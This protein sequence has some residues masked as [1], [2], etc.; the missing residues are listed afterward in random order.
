MNRPFRKGLKSSAL[1]SVTLACLFLNVGC[2]EA[3]TVIAKVLGKSPNSAPVE[4][5][6]PVTAAISGPVS[7]ALTGTPV[8]GRLAQ[9]TPA[10][11][12]RTQAP[13][14]TL[15]P[16]VQAPPPPP[17]GAPAGP[18]AVSQ[19][20]QIAAA[21]PQA[22]PTPAA[23][24]LTALNGKMRNPGIGPPMGGDES[25]RIE[26]F[27]FPGRDPFREPTEMLPPRC[28]PSQP[29]CKFD[30]SQLRLVGVMQVS[31]GNFKGMV[32]DPEGR[33]Y[34]VTT[35]MMIGRATVTQIG[36][37]G[38]ILHVHKTNN[39]VLMPMSREGRDILD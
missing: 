4:S 25:R 31:D 24:I 2:Q 7:L 11:L 15:G 22:A 37:K 12:P 30:H 17:Q 3:D 36:N 18:P 9:N 21:A 38:V 29:L 20:G 35:G 8:L 26:P 14:Q 19:P 1:L 28:L 16:I 23:S 27:S 34:F 10:P 13:Q 39:D 32:E 5:R 33:G 6:Q